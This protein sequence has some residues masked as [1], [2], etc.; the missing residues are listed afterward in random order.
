MKRASKFGNIKT[1]VDG[2]EF[3]SKKEARRYGELQLLAKAGEIDGLSLQPKFPLKVNG[4]L[5]C[6]Y[7]GDFQYWDRKTASDVVEDV[8]SEATR[9]NRAYRIKV[10]LLKALHGIS[11]VEV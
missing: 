10:K 8:K 2:I 1:V 6:S 3:S 9:K 7:I 5:V 4:S 11:V